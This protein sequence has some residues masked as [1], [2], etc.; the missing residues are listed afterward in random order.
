MR[1]NLLSIPFI[2]LIIFSL[3][4]ML[5]VSTTMVSAGEYPAIYIDP[6]NTTDYDL[7]PG[8][9]YTI[10]VKTNYT[11]N[12]VQSWQFTL[13]FNPS[14]LHGG[15]NR[16][17]IFTG[18][19]ANKK[20]NL[21]GRPVVP[22]SEKVYVGG[23]LKSKPADYTIDY[24][25]ANITFTTAPGVGAEVKVIY[26][27]GG[28]TN[29]D[30]ITTSKD[31]FA[32][33]LLGAFDNTAGKLSLT[34]AFF[35][36]VFEPAPVTSGPGT[37]ATVTFTVV[38][39]GITDITLGPQTKLIGYTDV[40]WGY[41]IF[42]QW[43]YGGWGDP[44]TRIDGETMPTHLQHGYF[45]NAQGS[46]VAVINVVPSQ[47]QA[48]KKWTISISVTIRNE[49]PMTADV[50]VTTYYYESSWHKIGTHI[51]DDLPPDTETT[52]TFSWALSAVGY[53]NHDI[54]AVATI[55]GL[56]DLNP[57][58][59][60]GHSSVKVKM[61]GAVDGDYDCDADDVFLYVSPSYGKV[62]PD[63]KFNKQCDFDGDNDCDADDVFV[64]VSP[65][66]GKSY[67]C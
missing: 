48:Y 5:N 60:E 19:G 45:K 30:L 8:Y 20:F 11:G 10:S 63:P 37:L 3:L 54:K 50:N 12:D 15:L 42:G 21:T 22:N 39:L 32:M 55:I 47:T 36:F 26:F 64:Y 49:G 38:G 23:I 52:E 40:R 46:D 16:T 43:K 33:F 44:I 18:D 66:Y 29:G 67:T 6:A 13:F 58:N 53:C 4:T 41:D 51:V 17:D 14:V 56:P 62:Y 61:Y 9:T 59:N 35:M 7:T 2:A 24:L 31:P 25:M 57:T 27:Y 28:V 34:G 1:K 65:N